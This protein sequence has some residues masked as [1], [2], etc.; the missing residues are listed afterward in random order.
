MAQ[1]LVESQAQLMI[2][3]SEYAEPRIKGIISGRLRGYLNSQQYDLDCEDVCSEA[4]TRLVTYLKEL[5]ADLTAGPCK[6]F[7]SYVAGIAHTACH[8]YF[9]QHYPARA[10]L[11]KKIRDLLKASSRLD[12]WRYHDKAS[13]KWVCGFV[14]WRGQKSSPNAAAWLD[15]LLEDAQAASDMFSS[16]GD[17]QRAK[18][19]DLLLSIFQV[20]GEPLRVS[21]VVDLVAHIRGIKDSPVL[22]LDSND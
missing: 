10:R 13:S 6:D 20:V 16:L 3:L 12:V 19:D 7:R 14:S 1:D 17:I 4:K 11:D 5:K 21:D 15:Y 18:I 8:D 9:R 22:S 2:L